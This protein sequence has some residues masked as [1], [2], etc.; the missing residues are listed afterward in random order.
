MKI[1]QDWSTENKGKEWSDEEL[2][3]VLSDSPTKTNCEKYA[4]AF[5]RGYGSIEQIY[6]WAM[7]SKKEIDKKR[8]GE[9]FINQIKRVSK[10]I[11][12]V[13]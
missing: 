7:V 11:G 2:V 10:K 1:N 4:R 3:V 5:K 12:W 9:K 6:R 13:A 8:A